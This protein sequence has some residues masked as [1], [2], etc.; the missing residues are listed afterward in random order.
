[1]SRLLGLAHEVSWEEIPPGTEIFAGD[2]TARVAALGEIAGI[3]V[4][5]WEMTPGE[6]RD[7]EGDEVF[8][9]VAGR[10]TVTVE[11]EEVLELRPGAVVHLRAGDRTTWLVHEAVRKV[12][13][14]REG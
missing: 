14:A 11:D 10:A 8:V 1:V 12:Y 6:V 5:V 9:V 3:A 4:G 2:P 7:V 13:F